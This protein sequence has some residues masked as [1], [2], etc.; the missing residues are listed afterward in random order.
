ME[1]QEETAKMFSKKLDKNVNKSAAV[2]S[3]F[4]DEDE[5]AR[6]F[7]RSIART[8]DKLVLCVL[9]TTLLVRYQ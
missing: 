8:L 7:L 2:T 1:K 5:I 3:G 6:E 9:Q 4:N